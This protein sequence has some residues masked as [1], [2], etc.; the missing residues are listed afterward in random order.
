LR[1][2]THSL[3]EWKLSTSYGNG[4]A[5]ALIEKIAPHDVRR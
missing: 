2:T 1:R 5:A 3:Y 4:I